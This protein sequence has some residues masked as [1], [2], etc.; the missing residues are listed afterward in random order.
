MREMR[1]EERRLAYLGGRASFFRGQSSADLL[2]RNTSV[3]GAKLIVH[4]GSFVPDKFNLM[5]P[6]WQTKFRVRTCWRRYD[7]IGVELENAT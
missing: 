7:E 1:K 3:S 6:A 2:I 5:I 4:N